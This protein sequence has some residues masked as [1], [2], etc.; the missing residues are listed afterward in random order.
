MF[1]Y[2][3]QLRVKD[4]LLFLGNEEIAMER[5]REMLAAIKDFEPYAA[6]RRIDRER[7]GFLTSKKLC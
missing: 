2:D 6:F 5:L 7:T 1:S 4:L 3:S